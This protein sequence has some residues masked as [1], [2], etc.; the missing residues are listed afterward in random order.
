MNVDPARMGTLRPTPKRIAILV[1]LGALTTLLLFALSGGR[2][3][4][5]AFSGVDW[6]PIL[7]AIMIHY[8]GFAVRGHRWQQLLRVMGHRLRYLAVLALMLA[9][10]FVSALVP[11]RAGDIL[12]VAALRGGYGSAPQATST[13]GATAPT[14]TTVPVADGL[15]SI[16]LERMLDI[17]AILTLGAGF[18]LVVL[19]G[20]LPQWVAMTYVAALVILALFG[21]ALVVAPPL[22]HWLRSLWGNRLWQQA[23]D[24]VVRFIESLRALARQPGR[25]LLV[26]V[27]SLYIWLCDALLLWLVLRGLHL[28]L[29]VGFAAFVALTV[30]IVAAVP[31]TPGGIGQIEVANTAL[32]ALAGV[33]AAMATAAVLLVRAISYW[34]FLVFTG[35]VT[36]LTGV[37]AL[38]ETP[39]S[40]TEASS[41]V[42]ADR[43]SSAS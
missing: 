11:A 19:R 42:P 22:M 26:V 36:A 31:I 41:I 30:D 35:I 32:L 25:A 8:S 5:G 21:I 24:F 7:L 34:T 3:A 6:R 33:P 29:D 20:A 1:A 14:G 28:P 10:W 43:T 9:G 23:L 18:G 40:S 27:E 2:E 39:V 12:R 38:A 37:G 13:T 15:G 16:V 4:L 17:L